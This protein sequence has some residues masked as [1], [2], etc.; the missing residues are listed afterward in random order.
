MLLRSL[1][2]RN[3]QR[4]AI[5]LRSIKDQLQDLMRLQTNQQPNPEIFEKQAQVDYQRH[6]LP[7]QAQFLMPTE[8]GNILRAAELRP[9]AKYGLNAVVCWPHL[10]MLLPDHPRNDLQEARA[11]LNTAARVWLWGLLF[12]VWAFFGFWTPWALLALPI[13]FFTMLFAYRWSLSAA[14]SY[15]DLLDAAF[16]LYRDELYKAL[17]WPL[18]EDSESEK[19]MGKQLSEYLWRGPVH[20]I[21]YCDYE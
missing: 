1:R 10:W 21:T 14:R 11:S 7:S 3:L 19:E 12:W 16:D 2:Q 17:R 6:W 20:S 8:L 15:G 18:P 4:Y 13:G 9:E 5:K